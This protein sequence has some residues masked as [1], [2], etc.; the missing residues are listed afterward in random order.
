MF[1]FSLLFMLFDRLDVLML[2]YFKQTTEVGLYAFA[3]NLVRPFELVPETLNV[4]FLPKVSKFTSRAQ[5]NSYFRETL[6]LT[7]LVAIAGIAL[8]FLSKPIVLLFREEYLPA[9]PLFQILVGAFVF[10]AVL[11][12]I[13]LVGHSLNKPQVFAMMAGINLVLS[14][15]G[16]LFFIPPFG[17]VGAAVVS[18]V[19]RILGGAIGFLILQHYLG[20]WERSLPANGVALAAA[21]AADAA[22]DAAAR[23]LGE[24]GQTGPRP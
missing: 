3:F 19:A 20:R 13:N 12:P 2:G 24:S 9:V 6:K 4:V 7:W 23:E 8:I 10:L 1:L 15:V 21:A 14:F 11:N 5:V 22:E 18:L 17:A 16:Y